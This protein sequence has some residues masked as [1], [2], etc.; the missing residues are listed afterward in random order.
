M[1]NENIWAANI[2]TESLLWFA[3]VQPKSLLRTIENKI[4]A[5]G[6]PCHCQVPPLSRGKG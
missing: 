4:E 6:F 5:G 3:A 2:L 1:D